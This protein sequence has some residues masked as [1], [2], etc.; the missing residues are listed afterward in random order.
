MAPQGSKP[1]A[2][3]RVIITME[4]GETIG[5]ITGGWL[6]VPRGTVTA[7]SGE[8]SRQYTIIGREELRKAHYTIPGGDNVLFEDNEAAKA[9]Y[10]LGAKITGLKLDV[11]VQ[12]GWSSATLHCVGTMAAEWQVF[13]TLTRKVVFSDRTFTAYD[14]KQRA[15]EG[16]QPAFSMFREGFRKLLANQSFVAFMRPTA[17]TASTETSAEANAVLRISAVSYARPV[18][19]PGSFPDLLDG[20][21]M[22]E[23]GNVLG[24]GFIISTDGYA[25]T[26]AHVVSGLKTVPVRL[27]NGI[28]LEAAVVQIR[29]EAD[30]AL[31]KLPG[32][33]FQ[34]FDVTEEAVPAIGSDVFAIGNP[35]LK[36]LNASVSKGVISGNRE[37]DGRKFIQTDASAN[38]GSSGGPLLDKSG[39]V[40]GLISWKFAAPEIQGL[41]FAV[42]IHVALEQLHIQIVAR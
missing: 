13:D 22:L 4:S 16:E 8:A 32:T 7:T 42:P 12:A 39:R 11:H 6:N 38:P 41:A 28:V 18:A 19:L 34:T 10:Q 30:V 36:E 21:V 29:E 2:F 9:R 23:P 25:L 17:E 1:V 37:I 31:I 33:S 24:S 14:K 20:F 5:H 40:L 27:R 3:Q 26:A 15:G 35:A